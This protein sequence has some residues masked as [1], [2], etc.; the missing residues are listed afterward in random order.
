[1]TEKDWGNIKGKKFGKNKSINIKKMLFNMEKILITLNEN[2]VREL[3]KK[4]KPC[5]ENEYHFFTN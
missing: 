4:I 5:S 2:L 1:M 3:P